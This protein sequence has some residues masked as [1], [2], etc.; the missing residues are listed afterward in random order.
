[1]QQDGVEAKSAIMM[2]MGETES[3]VVDVLKDLRSIGVQRIAMGQY[4]RPTRY[5]LPVKE[6]IPLEQ[7]ERY[8]EIAKELGFSWVKSGPMVR[9]SYHAE[10]E[11]QS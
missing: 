3:Q 11:Q 5:H 9:S 4:L 10:E 2:G 8:G 6:Y 7:F 1:M